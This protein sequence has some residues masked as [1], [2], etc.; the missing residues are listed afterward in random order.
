MKE[1]LKTT[2][3]ELTSERNILKTKLEDSKLTIGEIAVNKALI[4]HITKSIYFLCKVI[5][6]L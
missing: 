3:D 1:L 6:N 5:K 4:S 2:V